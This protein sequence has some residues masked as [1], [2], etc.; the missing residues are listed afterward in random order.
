MNS[1]APFCLALLACAGLASAA[2]PALPNIPAYIT[3]VTQAP[4]NAVGDGVKTNTTA[5]QNAI[6]DVSAKGG[7]TVE[8]PG[9][10]VYLT[11]PL[12]M[13]SKINLQIDAGAT[14]RM[15]PYATWNPTWAS[16][17]LLSLASLNNVA[18]SGGG[19]ID[20]QGANW[21][22][23][24]AGSGLY[25][26][27]FTSCN[28]VLVQNVTV[29]NAPKQQIVF[30]S[31]KGGNI[32]I[33]GVTIRAPSSHAGTPSHNTDGIDLVGTN[34]LVQNCDISTGDDNIALGTSSSGVLSSDILVT[35]CAFGDGHG[36]TIG[37]NT[38]GGVSNLTVIN[39]TFNGTDYGIRMKS[40]NNTTSPGAGGISQNL[41]YYNLGMTNLRYFPISI[42]SYYNLDSDP[43]G[44]SPATAAGETI[45]PVTANTPIWRNIVIS[46]LTAT[47]ASGGEAGIIWG[48]T[49]MPA[50]NITL[51]KLNITAPA[52]FNLYN[53]K[54][55]QIVDSHIKV[56]GGGNTFS[57]YNAQFTIT[58]STAVTNVFSM[59][60]LAS[61]NS[62]ALYN[63]RG[64]MSDASLL[65]ANPITLGASTLSNSTGV[66]L[67]AASVV[68]FA[69]G[70]NNT[71]LA[72]SGNQVLNGT[73][74]I[75]AGGGFG[76]G[77]CTLFA[78]TG[79]LS[80]SPMLGTRP[81]GYN[82]SLDTNTAKQVNLV[83]TPT[84]SPPAITNHPA[85]Q[86]VLAGSNVLF[87]V[88]ASGSAPLSY[89]WRFNSTNCL[90]DCTNNCL[91]I[92]NA[93]PAHAGGYRVLVTNSSGTATSSVAV[94]TVRVPPTI[95]DIRVAAGGGSVVISG[96]GGTPNGIYYV[97]TSTNVAVPANQWTCVATNQFDGASRF[98]F[99]NTRDINFPQSFYL[100]QLP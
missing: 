98:V 16:T 87:T 17:P 77:A 68:N 81:P 74:N 9:P 93:Q 58:N 45:D 88:G 28:T 11:G 72:V 79:N 29:S 24:N 69:L 54:D 46:N 40:D 19:G 63:T 92:S 42:H 94:L 76:T 43:T 75:I 25:M 39:C 70:T 4:Y 21:W 32:T 78:Y 65:G 56:T 41:Y 2:P 80:G 3:N 50:T 71:A 51:I 47:V 1:S 30:K 66:S 61:T 89:Q 13:K 37:G 57:L 8:I 52:N 5:I 44:I 14:L 84:N 100:L 26:I 59:D 31:S 20:G 64:T 99:T 6:N 95:G 82:Y 23:I 10:G 12:T 96:S 36:M 22:A 7:G 15:L 97:L 86:I 53:V 33:Q 85:S 60:G 27:Y 35:N 67:P 83:V 90:T 48:R 55:L 38:A 62:L 34:C 18:I 49:E 73:L 91:T